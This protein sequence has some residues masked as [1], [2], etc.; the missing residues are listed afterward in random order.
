MYIFWLKKCKTTITMGKYVA[1]LPIFFLSLYQKQMINQ[2]NT[3]L[4]QMAVSDTHLSNIVGNKVFTIL[5][6]GMRFG[7]KVGQIGQ[8]LEF[9]QIRFGVSQNVLSL[10]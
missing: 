1:E 2:I 10:I 4:H 3:H 9:F 7:P 5:Y 8:I 6:T